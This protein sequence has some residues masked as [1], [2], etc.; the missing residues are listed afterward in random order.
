MGN[1]FTSFSLCINQAASI[2]SL[3]EVSGTAY[4]LQ[5]DNKVKEILVGGGKHICMD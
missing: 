5:R 4:Q 1:V 3:G 2:V